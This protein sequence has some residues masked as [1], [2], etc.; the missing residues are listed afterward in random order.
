MASLY[1]TQA[2]IRIE[3]REERTFT[4]KSVVICEKPSQAGTVE[5]PQIKQTPNED[6]IDAARTKAKREG[7]HLLPESPLRLPR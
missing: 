6:M 3:P 1:L 5:Q 7:V 4:V 2:V